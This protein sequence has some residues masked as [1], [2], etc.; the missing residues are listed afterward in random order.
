MSDPG[1]PE[2]QYVRGRRKFP[3][4]QDELRQPTTTQ[5]DPDPGV[6]YPKM[7]RSQGQEEGSREI[8]LRGTN[9]R[10]WWGSQS[11]PQQGKHITENKSLILKHPDAGP[12]PE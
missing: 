3:H 1:E 12:K 11:L 4:S 10:I 2:L 8:N 6:S 9:P 5:Q 7:L